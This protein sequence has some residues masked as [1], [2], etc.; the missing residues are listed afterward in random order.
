MYTSEAVIRIFKKKFN[1]EGT[2]FEGA[3]APSSNS[4]VE[5]NCNGTTLYN[6]KTTER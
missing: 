4:L 5:Y 2:W 1:G 6:F 3:V